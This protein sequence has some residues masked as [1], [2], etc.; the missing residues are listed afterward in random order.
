MNV[1][2]HVRTVQY[3][4]YHSIFTKKYTFLPM[5][6]CACIVQPMKTPITMSNLVAQEELMQS[7]TVV[8]QNKLECWQVR[9]CMQRPS[10]W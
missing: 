1:L 8:K 2:C 7:F 3:L 6:R 4:S 9:C 10:S 5:T